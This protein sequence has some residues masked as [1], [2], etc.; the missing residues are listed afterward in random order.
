MTNNPPKQICLT[1]YGPELQIVDVCTLCQLARGEIREILDLGERME[2]RT[3]SLARTLDQII[4]NETAEGR[5][6][7]Y[8]V[9][10]RIDELLTDISQKRLKK[11]DSAESPNP[12]DQAL[13]LIAQKIKSDCRNFFNS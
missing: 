11:L 9:M 7:A 5:Q 4:S 1:L 10:L 2:A 3:D 6:L 12:L 8:D 13:R